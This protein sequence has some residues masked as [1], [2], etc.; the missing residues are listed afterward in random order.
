VLEA[1]PMLDPRVTLVI[2]GGAQ[3]DAQCE[4]LDSLM[5]NVS[6]L[7]LRDRVVVTGYLS[8]DQVAG[9][10]RAADVVLLPQLSATG[11]YT[12]QIAY[13]YGKPIL[14]SDLPCFT[15]PEQTEGA[16]LTFRAGDARILAAK[17]KSVLEEGDLRAR[18]AQGALDYAAHHSWDA[19]AAKTVEVYRDVIR[20]A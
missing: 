8:D 20:N 18:L 17:L 4:Y 1:L 12:V 13:A 2:A 7:G 6:S 10:M 11:S 16:L 5:E 9:A 3:T 15:Y 19:V 14:A